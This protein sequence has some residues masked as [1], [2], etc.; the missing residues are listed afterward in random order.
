M[1][2]RAIRWPELGQ[3]VEAEFGRFL[4]AWSVLEA[5]IEALLLDLLRA[6]LTVGMKVAASHMTMGKLKLAKTLFSELRGDD[7][8]LGL[9]A[10][11]EAQFDRLVTGVEKMN[12]RR[13]EIVHGRPAPLES[14][15]PIDL[16]IKWS[17][18]KGGLK[19]AAMKIGPGMFEKDLAKIKSLAEDLAALRNR[20]SRAL[21]AIRLADAD[22][23][24]SASGASRRF[25][26]LEIQ[27]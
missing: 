10:D 24:Q 3:E 13:N 18:G 25:L 2:E 1:T 26:E 6:D 15:P 17:G 16:W 22:A 7:P 27:E 9:S 8:I 12:E 14:D 5:E 23:I 19:A 21:C 4:I 11:R 20:L